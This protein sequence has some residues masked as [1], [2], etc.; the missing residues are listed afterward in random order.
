MKGAIKGTG[1]YAEYQRVLD[2]GQGVS[3]G[4]IIYDASK[5]SP[6]Y[7]ASSTVQPAGLYGQ[8]LIRY[9]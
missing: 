6:L 3:W 5:S 8:Y 4:G 9:V 2:H 1:Q 7:G